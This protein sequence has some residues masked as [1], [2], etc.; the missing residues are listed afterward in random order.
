LV[1][2]AVRYLALW[3]GVAGDTSFLYYV[4]ILVH[5]IIFGFFFV[6]GQVYVDKKAPPEMRAQAQGLYVLLC[7]GV[8]QF[9]GT[10]VNVKLVAAYTEETVTNWTPV[11]TI[12]TVAAV[13]LLGLLA[14]LF[15]DDVARQ[16]APATEVS[17]AQ[18]ADAE[19]IG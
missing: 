19:L 7:Y 17:A 8:G 18:D 4:A 15:R 5:G 2:L 14:L 16:G 13:V 9:V 6:G 1:A 3:A 10:F 11:F 12:S